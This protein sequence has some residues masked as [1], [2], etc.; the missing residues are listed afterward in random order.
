ML[1]AWVMFKLK[2]TVITPKS[3]WGFFR[4]SFK[5]LQ[6]RIHACLC[7]LVQ[8]KLNFTTIIMG[9]KK[10]AIMSPSLWLVSKQRWKS[11]TFRF[12]QKLKMLRVT[13]GIKYVSLTFFPCYL[14]KLGLRIVLS[15]RQLQVKG[16]ISLPVIHCRVSCATVRSF[17]RCDTEHLW[18]ENCFRCWSGS[19]A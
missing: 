10:A 15:D 14:C 1:F 8:E 3:C 17:K 5:K 19:L 2:E 11:K 12:S 4:V 18:T 16:K 7:L 6:L 9:Y 13:S